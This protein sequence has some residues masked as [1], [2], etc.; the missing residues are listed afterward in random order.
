MRNILFDTLVFASLFYLNAWGLT[1]DWPVAGVDYYPQSVATADRI[2]AGIFNPAGLGFWSSMG[3]HYAHSFTDTSYKGD[4]GAMLSSRSGFLAV[5]WLNHGNNIFRR[6]YTLAIG[7]RV[8]SNFYIGLSY[9]WFGGSDTFYKGKRDWKFGA[10]YH[11]R[12]FASLGLVLDRINEPKFASLRLKRLYRPGIALRPIGDKLTLSCDARWVEGE[13]ISTLRA[14]FLIAAGPFRGISMFSDYKT[15][16]QWRLGISVSLDQTTIGAHGRTSSTDQF[17]GGTYF[18]ELTAVRSES[19]F[20]QRGRTGIIE[21]GSDIVEEPRQKPILRRGGKSLFSVINTIRRGAEDQRIGALIV[22][23]DGINLD[24]ATAQ[25]LRSAISEYR[26]NG[27]KITVYMQ[28]G[29]NMEYYLSSAA[30]EILMDPTG[31]LEL[32]GLAATTRF[33]K[34]TMDKLGIRAQVVRTGPHKSFGDAFTETTLT[35][36]AREQ[37]DWLLDDF[38]SQFVDGI[39]VGRRILPEKVRDLIDAGPYTAEDALKEGLIDGLKYYD[40]IAGDGGPRRS[41]P[42]NLM[43]FYSVEDYNPRWSEPKK[44]AIVYAAGTILPG[45]S[46]S[47]FLEGK[48]VGSSTLTKALKK[49]RYDNS[50]RAVVFRVNSPGGDVFASEQIYRQLELLKGKKPLVV[51]MGGEAASGGYYISCP[52]DKIMAS[53]G[54][55]TG[56]IGVV[57]GKPDLSAFYEKI[58]I[59]NEVIRRGAHADIRSTSRPATAE[60]LALIDKMIWE[61]YDDFVSKVSTWRKIDPDSVDAMGQGRVWTGRQAMQLGLIDVYGG[62]WEAVELARQKAEID[63]DDRLEFEILPDYGYSLMPS[64]GKSSLESELGSFFDRQS[65]QSFYYKPIFDLNVK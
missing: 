34:G 3:L 41:G 25:E 5:E 47:S 6:K 24:F 42:V 56:S 48:T 30:D 29:G 10:M 8:A 52:G 11:P 43:S 13:D 63:P 2:S 4:D 53:P 28:Q 16:G 33:Y 49:I 9:S 19:A 14:D 23:I 18:V 57:M 44:I 31:L 39:S 65:Q 22:K 37:I 21:L 1:D 51:S 64:F 59:S 36:A 50:I 38:Y 32:K 7:D 60:E 46:G 20:S 17:A 35:A 55:V 58:G 15:E 27:K 61:Y 45:R 62:I 26:G 54:T 40:E 12:P